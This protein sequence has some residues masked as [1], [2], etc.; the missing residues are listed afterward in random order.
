MGLLIGDCGESSEAIF[1]DVHSERGHT[2]DEHVN[3]QIILKTVDQVGLVHVFLD[4]HVVGGFYIFG[5]PGQV[6]A[7]SLTRVIRLHD[8]GSLLVWVLLEHLTDIFDKVLVVM[9]EHVSGWEKVVLLRHPSL[10]LHQMATQHVL[11]GDVVNTWEVVDSLPW[12]QL[13]QDLIE[14]GRAIGP[15]DVPVALFPLRE[16]PLLMDLTDFLN[17]NV[18]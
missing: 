5:G 9:G 7:L 17:D 10:H 8:E 12:L 18:L 13:F 14:L 1:V 4:H 6:D 16:M 11:F 2:V 15:T 3:S